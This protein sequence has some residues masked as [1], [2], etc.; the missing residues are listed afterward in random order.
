MA[1]PEK[2]PVKLYRSEIPTE[3]CKSNDTR[4][5]W[6]WGQRLITVQ[7]IFA[8]TKDVE[9]KMAC[10]LV[11]TAAMIGDLGAIELLLQRLEGSP[12]SDEEVLS[13]DSMP[14]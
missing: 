1:D 5:A 9:T 13:A 14:L 8:Q 7:S 3:H 10:S 4:L 11:L 12:V 6:L 2:T